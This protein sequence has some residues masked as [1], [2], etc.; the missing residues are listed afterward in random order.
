MPENGDAGLVGER[1]NW[2]ADTKIGNEGTARTFHEKDYILKLDSKMWGARFFS[3]LL[4]KHSNAL[5]GLIIIE[6]NSTTFFEDSSFSLGYTL[7]QKFF[8]GFHYSFLFQR[9]FTLIERKTA[10]V[11]E[12]RSI[13]SSSVASIISINHEILLGFV[14]QDA[15]YNRPLL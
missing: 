5:E 15:E 6:E 1:R 11:W 9:F 2:W 14:D 8:H 7:Q 10:G 12:Q 13:V 3:N 4:L